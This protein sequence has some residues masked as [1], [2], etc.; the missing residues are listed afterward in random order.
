MAANTSLPFA[1]G[2]LEA[3]PPF[4]GLATHEASLGYH[5]ALD[6]LTQAIYYEA[7]SETPTGQRAVAQVVLNRV[8]HP[9][10]PSSICAVVYQGSERHTGCQ[11]TFTCDGSLARKP[12]PRSWGTARTIASAALAGAVEPAIGMATHYHANWVLPYWAPQLDKLAAVGAHIF[13][14]WKGPWGRRGAFSQAYTGETPPNPLELA[15]PAA[16]LALTDGIGTA[17]PSDIHDGRR[18]G[19]EL[20][21]SAPREHAARL[22]GDGRVPRPRADEETKGLLVD[23]TP[24]QLRADLSPAEPTGP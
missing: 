13:Y 7:A 18:S 12:S 17:L 3:S 20:L 6:C 1:L 16:L 5:A 21:T 4:R 11:F 23:E 22:P 10:F 19:L 8:R 14:R 15:S 24:A 9:A 2:A